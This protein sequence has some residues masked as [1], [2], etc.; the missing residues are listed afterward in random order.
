MSFICDESVLQSHLTFF[1]KLDSHAT[2]PYRQPLR[3]SLHHLRLL[4]LALRVVKSTRVLPC[5]LSSRLQQELQLS[6]N[7]GKCTVASRYVGSKPM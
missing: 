2:L 3:A 7:D 4:V 5:M 6:G 1:L